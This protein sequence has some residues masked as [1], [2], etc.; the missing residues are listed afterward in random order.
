MKLYILILLVLTCFSFSY[1]Q[2]KN[3][4][5]GFEQEIASASNENWKKKNNDVNI[6]R[7]TKEK[8]Q[9]KYSLNIKPTEKSQGLYGVVNE[10]NSTFNCNQI[11]F[12]GYMKAVD[13]Q[14]AYF[15]LIVGNI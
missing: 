2:E 11:T 6:R 7:D 14:G 1:S 9:G 10:I 13:V 4:N 8:F 5:L 3:Y 15:Y 12:K